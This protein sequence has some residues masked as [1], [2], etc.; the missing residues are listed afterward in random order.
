MSAAVGFIVVLLGRVPD[1]T[2]GDFLAVL[3]PQGLRRHLH[4]QVLAEHRRKALPVVSLLR[5]IAYNLLEM[6]HAVHLRSK[7][8]RKA[9]WQQLRD[10]V[11]D[12]LVWS[13]EGMPDL[14]EVCAT[15]P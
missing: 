4:R 10:W 3:D 7:T 1:S 15:T 2:L 6:L 8:A 13:A 11:R 14:P 5:I 9:A 12:A